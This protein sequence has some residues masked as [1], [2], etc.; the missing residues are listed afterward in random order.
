METIK[1]NGTSENLKNKTYSSITITNIP[2]GVKFC[3][4]GTT[5][6]FED[7]SPEINKPYLIKKFNKVYFEAVS[8]ND[9]SEYLVSFDF[10]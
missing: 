8:S 6:S 1:F 4:K 9:N 2:F 7:V 10:N 3:C 5:D